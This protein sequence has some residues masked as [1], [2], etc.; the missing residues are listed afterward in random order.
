M[1]GLGIWQLQRARLEGRPA[2]ALCAGRKAAADR[3]PDRAASATAQLPLFRHA[4]GVCLRPVGERATA[5]EN[6]A[7]E[8]GYV[9]I[10]D[11]ATGA[12]GPGMSVELGWSKNPNAK[13]EL[14]RRPGQRHHRAR[15]RIADAAGCG[16]CARRAWSRARRLRSRH[17]Q[18]PSVLRAAMVRLRAHGAR[19]LWAGGA[20]A[21]GGGCRPR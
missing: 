16:K 15:P 7:G 11:C 1:I 6:R 8:P 17:S 2:R 20:Q 19:H 4:T 3:I 9:H 18:Q 5:G 13:V 12:E 21:A 10:V 14:E